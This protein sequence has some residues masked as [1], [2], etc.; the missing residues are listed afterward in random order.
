[1]AKK[2]KSNKRWIQKANARMKRKGTVGSLTRA[3]KRAGFS[4]ALAYARYILKNKKK[5]SAA[6]IKKAN[7]AVN[8]NKK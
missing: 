1:M 4:S 5:F 2:R 6:M 7:F 8:V 3:A